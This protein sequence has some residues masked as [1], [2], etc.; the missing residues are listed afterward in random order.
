[1]AELPSS[2]QRALDAIRGKKE[3]NYR[4]IA[5]ILQVKP[6]TARKYL[7]QLAK[8]GYLEKLGG[9]VY[10]LMEREEKEVPEE[11]LSEE[12][13]LSEELTTEEQMKTSGEVVEP[14]YFQYKGVILPLKIAN[15]DQLF[16]VVKYRLVSAEEISY[17][18]KTGYLQAW[19]SRV[20]KNSEL[21]KEIDEISGLSSEE[22]FHKLEEIL[23]KHLK[24]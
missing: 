15:L 20:A 13:S 22:L 5:S 11:R 10:R 17:A 24:A 14:L 6:S 8:L 2:L 3:A 7:D 9:G 19:I 1:M 16:A 23:N 21:A 12:L 4:E 18:I